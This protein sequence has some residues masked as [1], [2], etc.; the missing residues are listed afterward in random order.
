MSGFVFIK[1]SDFHDNLKIVQVT[2]LLDRTC[3]ESFNPAAAGTQSVKCKPK[4][5]NPKPFRLRTDVKI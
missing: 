4:P 5:T 1:M 2:Q 3:K